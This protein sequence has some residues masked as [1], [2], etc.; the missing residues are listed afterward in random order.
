MNNQRKLAYQAI[1]EVSK[2]HYGWQKILLEYIHSSRQAYNKFL[3]HEETLLEHRDKILK[4][5]VQAIYEF[6]NRSIGAGKILKDIKVDD[7]I[8][9]DVSLKQVKRIMRILMISCITRVKKKNRKKNEEKYIKDNVL[10][11]KFTVTEPFKVWL[12]DSTQLVYG[13][14]VLHKVRLSGVLDLY[15][16]RLIGHLVTPSETAEAEVKLFEDT[17]KKMGAVHPLVHTDR[18]PAYTS[19]EFNNLLVEKK[20]KRSMSRPGTPYDNAP[21]ER[22][23]NDFKIRWINLHPVPK[24]LEELNALIEEGI[25]YFNKYDRSETRNDLT[26]DEYWAEVI[27]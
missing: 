11:Q 6:H 20:A 16:R 26:P 14:K 15:G 3:N 1:K 13:N 18:G 17:F 23:W 4:E 22:W 25:Y 8:K 2:D 12:A 10:N 7:K 21:M 5:R 24:T 19:N 9:F 27:K